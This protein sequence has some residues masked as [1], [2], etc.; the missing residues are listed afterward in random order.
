MVE[1][2]R[3]SPMARNSLFFD[4][5]LLQGSKEEVDAKKLALIRA[6]CLLLDRSITTVLTSYVDAPCAS[7]ATPEKAPDIFS[8]TSFVSWCFEKIGVYLKANAFKQRRGMRQIV[9]GDFH[10][11]DLIFFALP[12]KRQPL[13]GVVTESNKLVY[14]C[15]FECRVVE[16]SIEDLSRCAFYGTRKILP[17]GQQRQTTVIRLPAGVDFQPTHDVIQWL[18]NSSPEFKASAE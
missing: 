5:T 10:A 2:D 4:A 9:W 1:W 12:D 7:H 13:S 15:P 3:R 17:H 11:G 6:G 16:T 18:L 8:N 14:A